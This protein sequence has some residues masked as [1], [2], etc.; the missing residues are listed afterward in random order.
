M[1]YMNFYSQ[2]LTDLLDPTNRNLKIREDSGVIVYN[3]HV[4]IT[5]SY[6]AI[7]QH[8]VKLAGITEKVTESSDEIA[9]LL[10][11]GQSMF[12]LK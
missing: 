2:K 5:P 4:R 11:T 3:E 6:V 7:F 8:I 1:L 10:R 12:T 9:D